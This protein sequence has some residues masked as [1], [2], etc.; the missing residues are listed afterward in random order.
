MG[1]L[2]GCYAHCGCSCTYRFACTLEVDL[3]GL[4][5]GVYARRRGDHVG[6]RMSEW[7]QRRVCVGG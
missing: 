7:D 2:S 6:S 1:T 4:D 3:A 5:D